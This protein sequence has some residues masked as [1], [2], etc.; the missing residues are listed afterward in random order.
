MRL[1]NYLEGIDVIKSDIRQY[2]AEISG[3]T[4]QSGRVTNNCIFVCIKGSKTNGNELA[5]EAMTKGA[6]FLVVEE[7]N[8]SV[9][10]SGLPYIMV[11]NSRKAL[12]KMCA[13]HAGNPERE[14]K[15]IGVT[16]T[17]G[18]TST[19]RILKEIYNCASISAESLGTLDGGLTTPDSEDFFPLIRSMF[20]R[21]KK[22]VVM[23]VSS[24]ALALDK[25]YGVKFEGGIFTNLTPEH[26]D[27]HKD[28]QDYCDAKAK[29]FANT[30]WG[31]YNADDGYSKFV[32]RQSNGIDY[33]YSV[34]SN[35]DFKAINCNYYGI[36]GIEYDLAVRKRKIK[37]RSSLSGVFNV[38]NT[39]AAASAA[40]LDGIDVQFIERGIRS[41][42]NVSGRLEKV[43]LGDIPFSVF[44]DYAHTPDALE[45]V[46]KCVCS[47][48]KKGQKLT[49][50]FGCGGDRDRSK[51]SVMGNI[52]SKYADYVI[53]T[54]DNSRTEN[55]CDIID[56]I[57]KGIDKSLPHTVIEDRKQ[58]IEYAIENAEE[59]EIILLCGK[60]HEDYEIGKYGKRYFSEKEIAAN[61]VCKRFKTQ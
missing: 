44:I 58:A 27:F 18:K 13:K 32:C 23:E 1:F 10:S 19:C 25:L 56:E 37:I 14:L 2:D 26:L 53:V 36:D 57:M 43:E 20:D 52:A 7:I 41:V 49:V 6:S 59:D 31:L 46:L 50:L 42:K 45:N 28:M 60:G 47:F 29:L 4:A 9:I 34:N 5:Y 8:D 35:S 16:G 11:E 39:M 48:R 33:T 51:R 12:A 30:K 40:Y 61:A 24:H 55:A 21:G 22:V 17:N 15:L 54:S 38:Y 3:V